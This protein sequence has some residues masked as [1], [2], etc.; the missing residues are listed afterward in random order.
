MFS[1]SGLYWSSTSQ[2]LQICSRTG[3]E[4]HSMKSTHFLS[5]FQ[6]IYVWF[7]I[8]VYSKDQ[9]QNILWIPKDNVPTLQQ[10]LKSPYPCFHDC[11]FSIH[12]ATK[13]TTLSCLVSTLG[14][15]QAVWYEQEPK[16]IRSYVR[17]QIMHLKKWCWQNSPAHSH[18]L[19]HVL[20][21]FCLQR[22]HRR[23]YTAFWTKLKLERRK[24]NRRSK[25]IRYLPWRI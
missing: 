8:R 22:K 14:F 3:E 6:H 19:L 11:P 7:K 21:C 18:P 5:L 13:K 12:D 16:W 23:I 24:P 15:S 17:I 1:F 20:F 4:K 10:V 9:I 25:T 2:I